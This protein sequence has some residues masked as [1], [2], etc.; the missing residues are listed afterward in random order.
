[1]SILFSF[2]WCCHTPP[3]W[4]PS[5]P[6]L[7]LLDA[8]PDTCNP[9]TPWT[10]RQCTGRVVEAGV[11]TISSSPFPRLRMWTLSASVLVKRLF[12]SVRTDSALFRYLPGDEPGLWG[13]VHVDINCLCSHGDEVL[14]TPLAWPDQ[15]RGGRWELRRGHQLKF[16]IHYKYS[17]IFLWKK[18]LTSKLEVCWFTVKPAR[19]HPIIET[20]RSWL[21]LYSFPGLDL[22]GLNG[23]FSS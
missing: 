5:S 10:A 19:A 8:L 13:G 22:G 16:K 17:I 11:D 1:M 21:N 7:L 15:T 20:S 12:F 23:M 4:P 3:V 14:V 6:L 18:Q 9:L 2:H